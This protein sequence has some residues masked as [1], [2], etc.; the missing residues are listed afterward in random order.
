MV[1]LIKQVTA[2]T[3]CAT[4]EELAMW[5]SRC[6]YQVFAVSQACEKYLGNDKD[7]FWV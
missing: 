4:G 7:V 1:V 6:I 3:D 2:G 5:G